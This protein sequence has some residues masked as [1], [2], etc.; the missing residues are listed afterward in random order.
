MTTSEVE[1]HVRIVEVYLDA[2][3]IA[4]HLANTT[5]LGVCADFT[6]DELDVLLLSVSNNKHLPH[7]RIVQLLK[8]VRFHEGIKSLYELLTLL[9]LLESEHNQIVKLYVWQHI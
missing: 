4:E 7:V 5:S 8:V 1:V 2:A 9:G 6:V 3:L